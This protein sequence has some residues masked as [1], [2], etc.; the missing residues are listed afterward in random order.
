[1]HHVLT[2]SLDIPK[3]K[4]V[5]FHLVCS[6]FDVSSGFFYSIVTFTKEIVI[7]KERFA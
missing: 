3:P 6:S 4:Y 2:Y 7:L 1:M 5:C